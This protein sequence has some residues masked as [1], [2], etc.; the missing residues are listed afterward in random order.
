[1]KERDKMLHLQET[2]FLKRIA[3]Q[4]QALKNID[5]EML[6]KSNDLANEIDFDDVILMIKDYLELFKPL[7]NRDFSILPHNKLDNLLTSF[8][9]VHELASEIESFEIGQDEN[10]TER[11]NKII[12]KF[13]STRGEILSGI[14]LP[15]AVTGIQE[16]DVNSIQRK[17]DE[18]FKQIEAKND[19]LNALLEH[20]KNEREYNRKEAEE[21]LTNIRKMSAYAGVTANAEAFHNQSTAH[22][23]AAQ[24]WLNATVIAVAITAIVA[25]LFFLNVYLHKPES[26]PESIQLVFAKLVIIS[27]LTFAVVLCS[28]NY[29]SHKHNQTLYEHRATTLDTFEVFYTG[30]KDEHVKD[31]ILLQAAYAAFGNRQ[32]GF[33]SIQEKDSPPP[34]QIVDVLNKTVKTAGDM[35]KNTGHS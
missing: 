29:K 22:S 27:I 10:T 20:G 13:I 8:T 31:A 23:E 2:Q 35:G 18:L 15:L 28:K 1:L 11:Y 33:E 34:M 26:V 4:I 3:D 16:I 19:Q 5:L 6:Q 21:S 25:A 32:T 30:S 7:Y 14:L 24:K 9:K 12:S 17:A